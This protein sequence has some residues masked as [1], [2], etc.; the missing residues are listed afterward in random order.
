MA[1]SGRTLVVKD[2]GLVETVARR[3][4]RAG[5]NRGGRTL[6][7]VSVSIQ[8]CCFSRFLFFLRGCLRLVEMSPSVFDPELTHVHR[9]K[10]DVS[11]CVCVCPFENV[12]LAFLII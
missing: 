9:P 5:E 7:L 2:G 12:V 6:T 10:H 8:T 4:H 3:P 1:V 11:V